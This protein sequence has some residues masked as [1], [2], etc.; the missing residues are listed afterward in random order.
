MARAVLLSATIRNIAAAG[1]AAAALPKEPDPELFRFSPPPPIIPLLSLYMMNV[2]MSFADSERAPEAVE[3]GGETAGSAE[4]SV[5]RKS[6]WR[7]DECGYAIAV[8]VTYEDACKITIS[9]TMH[10]K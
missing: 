8:H 10:G 1:A 7:N 9:I 2:R 3:C 6:I 4:A 5:R